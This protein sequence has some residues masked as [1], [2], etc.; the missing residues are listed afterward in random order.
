MLGRLG[1]PSPMFPPKKGEKGKEMLGR[2]ALV[3]HWLMYVWGI[4][5]FVL[6]VSDHGFDRF[7]TSDQL[8]L[9]IPF[10]IFTIIHRKAR[11]I[12]GCKNDTA[13][14]NRSQKKKQWF[15]ANGHVKNR[16]GDKVRMCPQFPFLI[17]VSPTKNGS[18]LVPKALIL[19]VF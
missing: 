6:E 9:I 4:Y 7:G 8:V 11:V 2:L 18:R 3:I 12:C 14:G 15:G 5:F 19:I 16:D 17:V 1:K 10:I 13:V